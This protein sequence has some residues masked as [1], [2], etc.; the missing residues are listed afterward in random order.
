MLQNTTIVNRESCGNGYYLL[1]CKAVY[2]NVTVKY[3]AMYNV[4]TDVI[5]CYYV[6]NDSPERIPKSDYVSRQ[7]KRLCDPYEYKTWL[8]EDLISIIEYLYR[9]EIQFANEIVPYQNMVQS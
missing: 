3:Y 6:G 5:Q 8:V 4:I 1:K 7:S 9:Y 2:R